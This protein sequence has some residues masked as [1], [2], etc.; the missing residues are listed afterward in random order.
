MDIYDWLALI[1]LV[2]FAAV[3]V[4]FTIRPDKLLGRDQ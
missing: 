1:I 2:A 4:Y 3:G